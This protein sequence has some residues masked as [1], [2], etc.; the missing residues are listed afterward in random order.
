MAVAVVTSV[1]IIGLAVMWLVTSIALRYR[2]FAAVGAQR[3]ITI[4]AIAS[5]R[6]RGMLVYDCVYGRSIGLGSPV[7]WWLDECNESDEVESREL[8]NA[9]L[10]VDIPARFRS[11]ECLTVLAPHVRICERVRV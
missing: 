7:V 10:V 5:E 6:G 1:V 3:G 11:V 8:R 9:K 4:A 2:R